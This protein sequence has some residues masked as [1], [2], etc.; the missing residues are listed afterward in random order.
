MGTTTQHTPF[1]SGRAADTFDRV[2]ASLSD[3]DRIVLLGHAR[4]DLTVAE[5]VRLAA[6]ARKL[7]EM[8]RQEFKNR[9]ARRHRTF[10]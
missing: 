3:A 9:N 4:P 10:D 8:A 5:K 2:W 6:V 7:Q 1:A